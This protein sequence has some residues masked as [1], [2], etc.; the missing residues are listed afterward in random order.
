MTEKSKFVGM[1]EETTNGVT[2]TFALFEMPAEESPYMAPH[3][4]YKID[5]AKAGFP[6]RNE[7]RK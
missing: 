6:D 4:S 1:V 5:F 2:E 3:E 7:G